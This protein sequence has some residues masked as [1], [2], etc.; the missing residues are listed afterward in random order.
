MRRPVLLALVLVAFAAVPS[1]ASAAERRCGNIGFTPAS[2]DGVSGIRAEGVSCRTARS[3]ARASEPCG[4][5][6]TPGTVK[7]YRHRRFRCVGRERATALPSMRW[8]CTR[9]A[10]VVRFVR[11]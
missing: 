7:R 4:P 5:T 10:A 9:G 8:R 11:T 6:G 3:V 1:P 2:D